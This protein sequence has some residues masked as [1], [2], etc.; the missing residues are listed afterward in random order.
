MKYNYLFLKIIILSLIT[1]PLFAQKNYEPGYI[2]TTKHDTI[3]GFIRYLNWS[4]NPKTVDFKE[5]QDG[6]E[7]NYGLNDL[8]G[9]S[10]HGESYLRAEISV[11]ENGDGANEITSSATMRMRPDTVFLL[12]LSKAPKGLYYLNEANDRSHFFIRTGERFDWLVYYRYRIERNNQAGIVTVDGFKKQLEDYFQDCPGVSV[13]VNQVT[14]SQRSISKLFEQYYKACNSSGNTVI[15]NTEK[16]VTKFGVL[17][18]ASVTKVRFKGDVGSQYLLE[19]LPSSKQIAGGVSLDLI[20]PRTRQKFSIYNELF[21]T[22]FKTSNH[23]EQYTSDQDF[24]FMDY[25]L[26]FGYVKLNNFLRYRI[27]ARKFSLYIN[28]GVSNG[29]IV[30]ESNTARVET[31]FFSDKGRVTTGQALGSVRKYEQGLLGGVGAAMRKYS[32]E[33]RYE[34]GNGMSAYQGLNS[35]AQRFYILL[36]YQF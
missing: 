27:P 26:G 19:P 34:R 12:E 30:S 4:K 29:L 5:R 32:L 36:A 21:F 10:V 22:S 20:L 33:V 17:L 2:V 8:S 25:T 6:V 1:C 3:N 11:N 7:K 31:T 28:L 13:N 24:S 9:F 16:V 35:L 18:G 14:Y 23:L 15:F